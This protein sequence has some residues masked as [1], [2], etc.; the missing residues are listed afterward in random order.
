MLPRGAAGDAARPVRITIV[1]AGRPGSYTI[2]A[3]MKSGAEVGV[4]RPAQPA[5]RPIARLF[6]HR[7]GQGLVR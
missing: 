5:R 6:G 2:D 3:L 4:D 7:F 1:G